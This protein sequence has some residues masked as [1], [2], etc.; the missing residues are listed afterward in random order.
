MKLNIIGILMAVLLASSVSAYVDVTY[1]FSVP[2]VE[3]SVYNIN[4]AAGS[5]VS[6]FSG[7][8]P[9][10][11]TTTNG[12]LT[13]RYPDSLASPYGYATYFVSPG[14]A[15]F[16][17][18]AT[19][20]TFGNPAAFQQSYDVPMTKVGEC[21]SVIDEFT[22]T[23][24]AQANVPV[25]INMQAGLDATLLSAFSL[26][27]NN[28][29]YVPPQYKDNYY[30]A[31]IQVKL[32]VYNSADVLV[33]TQTQ[34]F[35]VFADEFKDV[36]FTW[37]PTQDGQHRAVI[38]TLVVDDQC[39]STVPA[40]SS[41]TFTV[42]DSMPM[43]E[44]YTILN[45]LYATPEVPIAGE[46]VTV[47]FT[48]L[49]NHANNAPFGGPGFTLSPI[50]TELTQ[51]V[52]GPNGII[53][54]ETNILAANPGNS[55]PV[56]YS[57]SFN[58]TEAG[59]HTITL[60][61]KGSSVLCTGLSNPTETVVLNMNIQ[62]ERTFSVTFQLSDALLGTKISG[63]V[64]QMDGKFVQT[65]INGVATFSGLK[66]G[67]YGY[68]ITHPNF[69]TTQGSTT[70]TDYDQS[71]FLSLQPG[72]GENTPMPAAPEAAPVEQGD[73][74][75][76]ISQVRISDAFEQKSGGVV[77]IY[78]TFGNDGDEKLE[79]VKAVV[80][81]QDLGVRDS[82]GPFD[83]KTSDERSE[84]LLAQLDE[85]TQ[86]GVYPVRITLHSDEVTRVLYREIE[87][88]E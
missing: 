20:H 4:N 31:D 46:T 49:S 5:S 45:G 83:L 57:F 33:N 14:Y 52:Q 80:V 9:A 39:S 67:A 13:V 19:W 25:I 21:R 58:A 38:T 82:I 85:N 69:R 11:A 34:T 66:A 28:L 43:N 50:Q 75:I 56:D 22:I 41:K 26:T 2:N 36:S 78:I 72:Q 8:F 62:A 70:I 74:K 77:P 48:K 17:G 76:G 79:N 6:G 53:V 68:V 47:H 44:C 23:N 64:I 84:L 81:I 86:P 40:S 59:L 35:T 55:N 42:D 51:K 60:M 30:S 29:E 1:H 87:V 71:I 24:T 3:A 54:Q 7:S 88:L 18:I 12:Q 61:G 63:A 16:E 32:E 37:T 73:F 10:G 65:D 27:D 15:P